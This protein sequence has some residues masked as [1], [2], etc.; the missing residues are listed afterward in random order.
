MD[1]L[2]V[3]T[4]DESFVAASNVDSAGDSFT[5]G[6]GQGLTRSWSE[7]SLSRMDPGSQRASVLGMASTSLGST[8]LAIPYVFADLGLILG[9]IVFAFTGLATCMGLQLLAQVAER[10]SGNTYGEMIRHSIGSSMAVF[11]NV[12]FMIYGLFMPLGGYI[13]L[14]GLIV[15][16]CRNIGVPDA[17]LSSHLVLLGLVTVF[18]I[19]PLC[20]VRTLSALRYLTLLSVVSSCIVALVLCGSMPF[21]YHEL[22]DHSSN[23]SIGSADSVPSDF[24]LWPNAGIT[25]L[26]QVPLQV[27]ISLNALTNHVNL[28]TTRR[29]LLRPDPQ[30]MNKV[31]V[32][33]CV[34]STFIYWMVG[35][36]CFLS[37]G[38][39]CIEVNVSSAW[40]SCTPMNVLASPRFNDVSSILAQG[41]MMVIVIASI[42]LNLGAGC[43]AFLELLSHQGFASISNSEG[44]RIATI[45]VCLLFCTFAGSY[46]SSVAGVLSILGGFCVATYGSALPLLAASSLRHRDLACSVDSAA[47]GTRRHVRL[48]TGSVLSA[49]C[50]IGYFSVGQTFCA[51]FFD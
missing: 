16:F 29:E 28:F 50:V 17:M 2:A 1:S 43:R 36:Q 41:L 49:C 23:A 21:K 14:K 31:I 42:V 3:Q 8:L 40:P 22:M 34:L 7:R 20:L 26:K 19:A 44:C 13:F 33:A 30:R 12:V 25:L 9:S 47:S 5:S 48:L 27:A 4:C 51:L 37:L 10:S 39:P 45:L 32:R 15:Q 18:P 11:S 35:V 46:L 6:R 38:P 24:W